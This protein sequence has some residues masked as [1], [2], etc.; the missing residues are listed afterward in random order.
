M[1][2]P[3]VVVFDLTYL[4]NYPH[5]QGLGR[6]LWAPVRGVINPCLESF[7]ATLISSSSLVMPAEIKTLYWQAMAPKALHNPT[8]SP[9]T[10]NSRLLSA[11]TSGISDPCK[12]SVLS[13]LS[14]H[15]ISPCTKESPLASGDYYLFWNLS[16]LIFCFTLFDLWWSLITFPATL[17]HISLTTTFYLPTV[18][19]TCNSS[20]P[21]GWQ[22]HHPVC[23][24]N[25]V[26]AYS[27]S[28]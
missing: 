2:D 17:F 19:L 14:G 11:V 5:W 22:E 27:I 23:Q 6:S 28:S 18:H 10:P 3:C 1:T 21:L 12:I 4:G 9:L 20:N 15:P 16:A 13:L 8:L 24:F 7:K 25:P 26:H